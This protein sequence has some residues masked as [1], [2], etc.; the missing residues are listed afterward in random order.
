MTTVDKATLSASDYSISAEQYN[1]ITG[2]QRDI[3][4]YAVEEHDSLSIVNKI[5]NLAESLVGSSVA[6]VMLLGKD[7]K[8]TVFAGPSISPEDVKQLNG[9][10]P[11]EHAGSCGTAV[12]TEQP[13]FV[14]KTD[15]DVRWS[16]LLSIVNNLSLRACWSFPIRE[17]KD[18]VIGSFAL[19]SFEEREPSHFQQLVME[20]CAFLA[21]IVLKRQT[22]ADKLNY[23]I[24][25][26][27]LTSLF[28][29]EQLSVDIQAYLDNEID[30]MLLATIGL[31]RF[32]SI[33]DVYGH[34]AG[35]FVILTIS[36]RLQEWL[37]LSGTVYRMSGDEFS[38][39]LPK[40]LSKPELETFSD[41]VN[42]IIMAPMNYLDTEFI[43]S[44]SIGFAH[45]FPSNDSA[46]ELLKRSD[47]AMYKAKTLVHT[48]YAEFTETMANEALMKQSLEVDLYKAVENDEFELYFQPIM[49]KTG[50]NLSY[51]EALIRWNHP[52]KGLIP[53]LDFIPLAE[54]NGMISQISKWVVKESIDYLSNLKA[55]NIPLHKVSIN[56]SGR[57]FNAH[58]LQSLTDM[59]DDAGY[60]DYFEFELLESYLMSNE[61]EF[62]NILKKI[63]QTGIYISIDDFGTGYSSFSY[64]KRLPIDKVKID[65]SLILDIISDQNDLAITK[66][67]VVLAESLK[68]KVV[69]EGVETED[70][71]ALIRSLNVD[72][73]QGYAFSKPLKRKALLSFLTMTQPKKSEFR[74]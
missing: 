73:M 39:L 31:D 50:Q 49:E 38:I 69:A 36:K 1:K 74:L 18:K 13:V 14:K 28:N 3:L 29:R 48:K 15:T 63:R 33:N 66:A 9:L 71:I 45:S 64:L 7:G 57:E 58:H 43:L 11:G 8:L 24:R 12:Y 17:E 47:T 22:L 37:D 30:G 53:P 61:E 32:K 56:I 2:L 46:L 35:D 34:V 65:Q 21:G 5:C 60:C 16:S 59:I 62:I 55:F 70:H 54:E 27:T 19:S 25:H 44:A 67:I 23:S 4:E 68:L 26:D 51:V 72:F 6:S 40:V 41:E 52:I 10:V 20:N 42:R